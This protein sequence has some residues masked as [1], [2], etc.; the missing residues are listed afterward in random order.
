M[1]FWNR[2]SC[3][4][5]YQAGRP[6]IAGAPTSVE[7]SPAAPWQG[8]HASNNSAPEIDVVPAIEA[9]TE[10]RAHP[11]IVRTP[12]RL[13]TVAII[14][15]NGMPISCRLTGLA[16]AAHETRLDPSVPRVVARELSIGRRGV[17]TPSEW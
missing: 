8:T 16:G 3:A 2:S 14:R 17:R 7:P 13:P 6:A 11:V 4:E 15:T 9:A 1:P 12:V 10:L 5:T